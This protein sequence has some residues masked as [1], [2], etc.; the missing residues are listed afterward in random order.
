MHKYYGDFQR[1][2]SFKVEVQEIFCLY[3]W[4]PTLIEAPSS[5]ITKSCWC[6]IF[7]SASSSWFSGLLLA[8]WCKNVSM[9]ASSTC[10]P[11]TS[12]SYAFP[13]CTRF[14]IFAWLHVLT[15]FWQ[16]PMTHCAIY[17]SR[18]DF[19]VFFL[20]SQAFYKPI[21]EDCEHFLGACQFC[22]RMVQ[23]SLGPDSDCSS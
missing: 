6:S 23:I 10:L 21:C 9:P 8:G 7:P 14:F 13:S 11:A 17:F 19:D 15:D 3:K 22:L 1:D 2:N 20:S 5:K 18:R 16:Q 12:L 4:T